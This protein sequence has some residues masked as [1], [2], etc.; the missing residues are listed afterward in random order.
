[1]ALVGMSVPLWDA[2]VFVAGTTVA[3]PGVVPAAV[4]PLPVVA[5]V[6]APLAVAGVP[7]TATEVPGVDV[8]PASEVLARA[9]CVPRFA[10]TCSG[11]WPEGKGDTKSPV[12]ISVGV[13]RGACE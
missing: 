13:A 3:A 11:S 2:G 10:T 12:E 8:P 6:D 5:V 7:V 1:M 4:P 9:V